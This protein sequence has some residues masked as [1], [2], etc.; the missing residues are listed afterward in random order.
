M[1]M[2]RCR[3]NFALLRSSILCLR[4]TRSSMSKPLFD[5]PIALQH[6]ETQ[7]SLSVP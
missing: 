3:L 4:G 5:T 1:C 7:P 2:I 6:A